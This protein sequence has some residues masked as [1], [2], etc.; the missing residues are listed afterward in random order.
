MS[1]QQAI[2][3]PVKRTASM[4]T[5][6]IAVC[7]LLCALNVVFARFF[8]A[9]PSAVARFSI[10]AV[11][12]VLAGYFF[13]PISGMMVG[14]VGDT[15]GCLFSAYG[16]DP[17]ISVSPM[18]VGAFAGLMRPLAYKLEKPWDVWK[19]AVTVL[20]GKILGSVVWTSL[21]LM[22]LG[23]SKKGLGVL[24]S[25]RALEALMEWA[26]DS[27]LVFLLL[28][29]GLFRRAGMFPPA[30]QD[31]KARSY[32]LRIISGCCVVLE[33]I[34]LGAGNLFLGLGFL[35]KELGSLQRIGNGVLY[36]L[37]LILAVVLFFVAAYMAKRERTQ[38]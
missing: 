5:R 14:F 9:M 17:I 37:P 18:L 2:T 38:Q 25:A 27:V 21:C 33:I 19:V 12:I 7:A 1:K 34:L 28:R 30:K 31:R 11:P 22:W 24:M 6:Q 35:N 23:Y 4:G 15:V 10:E 8:T 16:W 32:T 13:G 29:T 26:L 20:P 3:I 36:F